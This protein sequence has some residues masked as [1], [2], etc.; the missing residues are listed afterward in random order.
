MTEVF[1]P[2][3]WW[4]VIVFLVITVSF[5]LYILF[6]NNLSDV[7]WK[8]VDYPYIVLAFISVFSIMLDARA[9]LAKGYLSDFY[10]PTWKNMNE[11]FVQNVRGWRKIYCSEMLM[12]DPDEYPDENE[13]SSM[14]CEWYRIA[15]E[16]SLHESRQDDPRIE[17]GIFN[18]FKIPSKGSSYR[19][20]YR[21]VQ[22]TLDEA[23]RLSDAT[24]DILELRT[25]AD[26]YRTPFGQTLLIFSPYLLAIGMALR[27]TKV[28]GEI[29]LDRARE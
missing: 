2:W 24:T 3:M 5:H 7:G 15:E 19:S 29:L 4:P 26:K 27:L 18:S 14:A 16:M 6:G 11:Q 1:L 23:K 22:G 13:Q 8:K 9:F 21:D 12:F 28:T 17:P 25:E 20:P 10:E